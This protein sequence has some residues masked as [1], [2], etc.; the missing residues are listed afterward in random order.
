MTSRKHRYPFCSLKFVDELPRVR[1]VEDRLKETLRELRNRK[2]MAAGSVDH[3][4]DPVLRANAKP[5]R[6]EPFA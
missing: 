1:E 4:N 2:S 5:V 3:G 6:D